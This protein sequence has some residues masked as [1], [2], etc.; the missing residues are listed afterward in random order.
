MTLTIE[1]GW[2]L[3]PFAIT[4]GTFIVAHWMNRDALG[5]GGW[6]GAIDAACSLFNYLLVCVVPSLVAWLLW[7]IFR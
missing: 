7:S 1:C 4:V 3:L 5:G 6:G 2:W